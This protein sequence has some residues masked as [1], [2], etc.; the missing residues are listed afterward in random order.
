M[1]DV[2][3]IHMIM[4]IKLQYSLE[5]PISRFI[6]VKG[7]VIWNFYPVWHKVEKENYYGKFLKLHKI[8]KRHS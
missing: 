1:V 3:V 7:E 6:L 5:Q 8:K 4:N 2:G